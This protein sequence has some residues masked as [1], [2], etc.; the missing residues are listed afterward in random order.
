[1]HW[2]KN[3]FICLVAGLLLG[4]L[5]ASAARLEVVSSSAVIIPGDPL[6]VSVLGDSEGEASF[7][8][9]AILLFTGGVIPSDAAGP[10]VLETTNVSSEWFATTFMGRCDVPELPELPPDSCLAV[11]AFADPS[12]IDLLPGT[13]SVFHFDT[14]LAVPGSVLTFQ[15]APAGGVGFDFFSAGPSEIVTVQV[16]PEPAPAALVALG[17]LAFVTTRRFGGRCRACCVAQG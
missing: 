1:M 5:S 12:A 13:F 17:L 3:R 8:A 14:S 10:F 4:S 2:R 7:T 6:S 16:I 11:H 9:A 15:A